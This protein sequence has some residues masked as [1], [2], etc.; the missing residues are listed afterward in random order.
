M[1]KMV[2]DKMISIRLATKD[3]FEFYYKLKSEDYNVFWGGHEAKPEY[4]KL[5][6]FF[7]MLLKEQFKDIF[8]LFKMMMSLSEN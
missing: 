8:T 1:S 2:G 4:A 3:D 6:Q 5:K 7:A